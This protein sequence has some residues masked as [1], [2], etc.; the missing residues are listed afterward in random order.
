MYQQE[1]MF[2]CGAIQLVSKT[3]TLSSDDIEYLNKLYDRLEG[4]RYTRYFNLFSVI[5]KDISNQ[6][7]DPQWI[8]IN[9]KLSLGKRCIANYFLLYDEDAFTY[10]HRDSPERVTNTAIT[11]IDKS[12]DLEGGEIIISQKIKKCKV[13]LHIPTDE[14]ILAKKEQGILIKKAMS[15]TVIP[16]EVGETVWYPAQMMHGVSLVTRGYRKVLISW[17]KD[18]ENDKVQKESV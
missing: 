6:L 15:F 10:I 12:S 1:S 5:R 9:K 14:D 16:Q 18:N 11:L 3:T 7:Q 8:S 17:Y 13:G 4:K 2:T